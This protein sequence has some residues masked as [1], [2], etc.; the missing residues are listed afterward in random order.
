[1]AFELTLKRSK[2]P[3]YPTKQTINLV[4]CNENTR[5]ST[6]SI[7]VFA[8]ALIAIALFTKFGIV[9]VMSAASTSTGNLA[10]AQTQLNKLEESNANYAQL[11]NTYSEYAINGLSDEEKSLADRAAIFS[12][13]QNSVASSA[14]LQ[15][16]SIS[17]NTVKLQFS[18]TSLDDLSHVVSSI[19]T[20]S[21]VSNV[22]VST[23]KTDKN[24][25][26]VS[27]VV[28]TLKAASTNDTSSSGV[29]AGTG[30]TS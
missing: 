4:T 2:N 24:D 27:T 28:I 10:A 13:L 12:L 8:I 7:V 1:M 22:S 15:S 20:N 6:R 3:V 19:E 25:D 23:A 29:T 16:V 18:N 11:Q 30:A 21:I 26:V 5:N 9:D 17:R 14:N